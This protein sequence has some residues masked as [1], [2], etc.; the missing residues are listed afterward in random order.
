MTEL[1]LISKQ[2]VPGQHN[3]VAIDLICTHI[4]QQFQERS[5]R[6]RHKIAI[7]HLYLPSKSGSSTPESRLEDLDLTVL[8]ATP[9][10]QVSG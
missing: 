8:P 3:E 10:V 2:I 7:P 6:F 5:K 4:R 1:R 9:Q